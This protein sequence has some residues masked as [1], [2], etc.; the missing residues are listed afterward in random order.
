MNWICRAELNPL[1][2]ERRPKKKMI[3]MVVIAGKFETTMYSF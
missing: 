3:A 1:P 2:K